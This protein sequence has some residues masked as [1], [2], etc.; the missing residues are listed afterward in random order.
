MYVLK[1]SSPEFQAVATDIQINPSF[2]ADE[3][4]VPT[5]VDFITMGDMPKD[6]KNLKNLDSMMEKFKR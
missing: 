6:M 1:I 2:S 4:T 3:F 5:D